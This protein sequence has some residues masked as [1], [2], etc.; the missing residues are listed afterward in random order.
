MSVVLVMDLATRMARV[1]AQPTITL[2]TA[3]CSATQRR[4]AMDMVLVAVTA[5]VS[6]VVTTPT[7]HAIAV[8]L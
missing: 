8:R 7:L 3:A 1:H 5:R 2:R 4:R 6:A